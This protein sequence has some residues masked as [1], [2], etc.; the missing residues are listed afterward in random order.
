M[1]QRLTVNINDEEDEGRMDNL[2]D[3]V[4]RYPATSSPVINNQT[5]PM[6]SSPA[7]SCILLGERESVYCSQLTWKLGNPF[8][9]IYHKLP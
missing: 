8:E 7:P 4:N 6:L 1:I 9:V 5:S 2:D 3:G